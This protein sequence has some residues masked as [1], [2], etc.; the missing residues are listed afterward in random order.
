M[1]FLRKQYCGILLL[2]LLVGCASAQLNSAEDQSSGVTDQ[3]FLIPSLPVIQETP[4]ATPSPAV[5][6]TSTVVPEVFPPD[7]SSRVGFGLSTKA[8][9]KHW[10]DQLHAGWYIDW[11]VLD[12]APQE[13]LPHWQ[14]V[15]FSPADSWLVRPVI[16]RVRQIAR[17]YP[18]QIWVLGNEPDVIWQD[19]LPAEVYAEAYHDLYEAIKAADPSA[20]VSPAAISQATDIRLAYLDRV[21]AEYQRRYHQPLPSDLW[22]VHGFVLREERGSWGVDIPPGFDY[23]LGRD[24]SI[25]DHGRLDLFQ[26]H[27]MDFRQWMKANGY[28]DQ[29]LGLT[30]FGILMPDDLGFSSEFRAQYLRA[31]FDWLATASDLQTGNP[32]DANR[33]VQYWAWFSLADT[34][35]PAPNL[36]DISKGQLTPLGEAFR[37]YMDRSSVKREQ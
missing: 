4:K 31:T 16:E 21:L 1:W 10:A 29:P 13:D 27:I 34:L 33:L 23:D 30:E 11:Q 18:G 7:L 19:N 14:M 25:E 17:R 26:E 5:L 6:A 20:Q 24:Y 2:V 37:D 8:D 35:Y 3:G 32:A 28:R 22:T 15:R 9:A 36:A 12:H